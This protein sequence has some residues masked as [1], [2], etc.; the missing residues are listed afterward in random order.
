[1]SRLVQEKYEV[2]FP[3]TDDDNG[4]EWV[5]DAAARRKKGIPGREGSGLGDQSSNARYLQ[6]LPPGSDIEAQETSDQRVMPLVMGGETDISRDWNPA[7]VRF[8]YTHRQMRPTDDMYTREHNDAF[9]DE[10][11]VD[12]VTGFLERNNMLD[13]E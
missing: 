8:G 5:S 11:T 13:R 10:V 7:A 3:P 1:M 6:S 12:G 2:A 9:Y 4:N